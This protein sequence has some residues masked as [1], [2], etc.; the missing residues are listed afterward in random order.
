MG[1]FLKVVG[2]HIHHRG[3]NFHCNSDWCPS[4]VSIIIQGVIIFA[5]GAIYDGVRELKI[6]FKE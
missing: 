4:R 6:R 1:V 3:D 2:A 5:L